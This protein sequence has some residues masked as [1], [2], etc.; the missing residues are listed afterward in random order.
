MTDSRCVSKPP[1]CHL[2]H[3]FCVYRVHKPESKDWKTVGVLLYRKHV[4]S[5]LPYIP[6]LIAHM[7]SEVCAV[8]VLCLSVVSV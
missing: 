6:E 3:G 8:C 4:I 1:D 7:E 2:N 5:E